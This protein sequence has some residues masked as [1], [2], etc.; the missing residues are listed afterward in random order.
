VRIAGLNWMHVEAYLERDDR[1]ALPIGSTEQHGYLSLATDVILAE[2]VSVE[3][4]EPLGVPVL[5]VL[6]FG[7]APG[8]TAYPGTVSLRLETL[9]AVLGDALDAL[10]G[11]GFRRFLV[12]NGHGGNVAA[13]EPLLDW[14]RGQD[15]ARMRFHSWYA[16]ERVQAAAEALH[17]DPTHANWFENF[18]WTRLA[19]VTMPPEPKAMVEI[20]EMGD[21]PADVRRALGDGAFG[22]SYARPDSEMLQLWEVAVTEVRNL[23]DSGW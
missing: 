10:H 15:G 2:R 5:P 11:Q 7:V 21:D 6:P 14:A 9:I 16:G 19:R 17:P 20:D 13:E 3:A 23:L 22:G 12:V 4:A 8:F 18:P 1:V